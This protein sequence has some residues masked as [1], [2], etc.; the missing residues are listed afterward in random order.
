MER[1]HIQS[2]PIPTHKQDEKKLLTE[3]FAKCKKIVPFAMLASHETEAI[4]IVI[5]SDNE[6]YRYT[7]L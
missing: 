6:K 1:V 3:P 4:Y 5:S 2:P 7:G